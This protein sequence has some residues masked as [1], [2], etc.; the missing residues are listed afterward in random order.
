MDFMCTVF[1][2]YCGLHATWHILAFHA[3]LAKFEES[4]LMPVFDTVSDH[5]TIYGKYGIKRIYY[6]IR[7]W[8]TKRY[9]AKYASCKI[10]PYNSGRIS[11]VCPMKKACSLVPSHFA[12]TSGLFCVSWDAGAYYVVY[13]NGW[14]L[15][16][17]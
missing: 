11:P 13:G 7:I 8:E 2:P 14:P 1:E 16:I 9:I 12:T 4:R 10:L 15:T 5:V 17:M 6:G 3:S